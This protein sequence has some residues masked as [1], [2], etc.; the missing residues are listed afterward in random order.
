MC[1]VIRPARRPDIAPAI[2]TDVYSRAKRVASSYFLYHDDRKKA[3]PGAKPASAKPRRKRMPASCCQLFV[4]PI[5]AA[6]VPQTNP[7]PGRNTLGRT[8]VR[9]IFAGTSKTRYDRKNTR[10]MME[11]WLEVRLK[12]SSRPP[13]LALLG[14]CQL[15]CMERKNM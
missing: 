13:V 7:N 12:S 2:G 9:I 5:K 8:R 6:K 10:T 14:E 1:S 11:Y 4:A 15:T 3:Q